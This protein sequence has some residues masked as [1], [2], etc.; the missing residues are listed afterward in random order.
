MGR[1]S[2]VQALRARVAELERGI[3]DEVTER[4]TVALEGVRLIGGDARQ[5]RGMDAAQMRAKVVA[6]AMGP[7]AIDGACADAIA[8]R[9]DHLTDTAI[10]DPVR[11]A[12][13]A[14]HRV[15]VN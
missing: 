10:V 3:A 7:S 14:R 5:F 4:V 15:A 1:V 6:T 9:F 12:L 11:A 13:M 8:A 2:E